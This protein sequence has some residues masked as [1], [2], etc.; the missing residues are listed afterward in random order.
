MIRSQCLV[1]IKRSCGL[2]ECGGKKK[3]QRLQTFTFNLNHHLFLNL[4]HWET[5]WDDTS[6]MTH[7][8]PFKFLFEHI[9]VRTDLGK[10]F[11]VTSYI[12]LLNGC[13]SLAL[14][15]LCC[16]GVHVGGRGSPQWSNEWILVIN[17]WS[18]VGGRFSQTVWQNF[19]FNSQKLRF[20]HISRRSNI[21]QAFS[22]LLKCM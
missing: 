14:W 5:N 7:R 18:A 21:T 13:Q 10:H 11:L 8:F 19:V 22:L 9:S 4:N 3:S 1:K 6:M 17:S 20:Q 12:F 15:R 2:V 16:V